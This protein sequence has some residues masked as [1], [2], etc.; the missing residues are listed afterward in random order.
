MALSIA[1][2]E[3]EILESIQIP[4]RPKALLAVMEESKQPEPKFPVIAKA[5]V[6]DVSISAAVLQVVN[7]AAF[8]RANNITSIDQALTL[9]GL[10]RVISI[11]N[12][13]ALRN[14]AQSDVDMEQFWEAASAIANISVTVCNMLGLRAVADDAY[15]LGL[16]HNAGVPVMMAKFPDYKAFYEQAVVEGWIFNIEKE[17]EIYHTT[18][19]TIGA[20][21][22]QKWTLPDDLVDVVYNL[23]YA[24]GLF[25]SPEL[26]DKS[27]QLLAILK[28]AREL[29]REAS[30]G[31]DASDEWLQ[32]ESPVF[33]CLGISEEKY[34]VL[35]DA[36][37]DLSEV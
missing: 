9:L 29:Y 32:V 3:Q 30:G 25:D 36:T 6:E 21:L 26:S 10:K 14:A 24:E 33:E 13:V 2:E 34:E 16:F 1:P 15:T 19:T 28:L 23:H 17:M 37:K 20:L 35:R 31:A 4:P 8:R 22:A 27:K 11:V 18:H 7:S 12:A 5:I